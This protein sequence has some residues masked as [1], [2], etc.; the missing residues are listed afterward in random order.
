MKPRTLHAVAYDESADLLYV[1][2]GTDLNEVLDN[3]LYYNFTMNK[4]ISLDDESHDISTDYLS[5]KNSTISEDDNK[6]KESLVE[7]LDFKTTE[8][9][10][11]PD[12]S[13]KKTIKFTKYNKTTVSVQMFAPPPVK[14]GE[15][16][17]RKKRMI[18]ETVLINEKYS[19]YHDTFSSKPKLK[20]HKMIIVSDGLLIYGGKSSN[21]LS[22]TLWH[23]NIKSLL[24]SKK[25]VKSKVRPPPVW[26]HCVVKMKTYMYSFGGSTIGGKFISD[27]YRINLKDLKE[28]EKVNV[29]AGKEL[30]MRLTGHSCVEHGGSILVFGGLTT[31]MARFSKLTRKLFTFDS[32][33]SVWSEI[34][35]PD[36]IVPPEMAYHTSVIVGNYMVVFGGYVHMHVKYEKCYESSL[37]FFNLK[38]HTWQSVGFEHNPPR[39]G[40]PKLQGVFGHGAVVRKNIQI[41]ISGGYHGSVTGDLLGYT[42]PGTLA[43]MET[44]CHFYGTQSSCAANPLCGWCGTV[45]QCY[46]AHVTY[47][48]L[49]K[50]ITKPCPGLCSA[51]GNC[52]DCTVTGAGSCSWCV[53]LGKCISTKDVEAK[54]PQQDYPWQSMPGNIND[55]SNC[56]KYDMKPGVTVSKYSYVKERPADFYPEKTYIANSSDVFLS[57]S[58]IG[59]RRQTT[60]FKLKGKIHPEYNPSKKVMHLQACVAAGEGSLSLSTSP[61]ATPVKNVLNISHSSSSHFKRTC[62]TPRWPNTGEFI[63]LFP[64][65]LTYNFEFESKISL[66]DIKGFKKSRLTLQDGDTGQVFTT[67]HLEP[68]KNGSCESYKYCKQ[69]VEDSLC[70]WCPETKACQQR[71]SSDTN[72]TSFL[73]I[74]SELCEDCNDYVYCEQCLSNPACQWHTEEVTCARKGTLG[75]NGVIEIVEACPT[76]C[77][78]RSSCSDCLEHPGRCVWCQ[79]RSECLL[80]SVYTSEFQFGECKHWTDLSDLTKN[81]TEKCDPCSVQKTCNECQQVLG[82]GWC[83]GSCTSKQDCQLENEWEY[84]SCPDIDECQLDLHNCHEHAVCTNTARSFM[85]HCKQGYLGDGKQSCTKTCY[86]G[87]GEH[88]KCSGYPNYQCQ[89]NLGWTGTTCDTWCECN[90]FSTCHT[91]VG[92]CDFC[93]NNTAGFNCENCSEG[94]ILSYSQCTSCKDYCHGHSDSCVLSSD[95]TAHICINCQN[96]TTGPRCDQCLPGTF[97]TSGSLSEGCDKC[98]CNGHGDTCHPHT[99]M[100]CNCHN[101][102]ITET[103]ITNCKSQQCWQHQCAKC[104]Q[105]FIGDPRQG[106]HCYRAMMVNTDY[107][108]DDDETISQPDFCALHTP[109]LPGKVAFFAVQ[110]KFM[111]VHIRVNVDMMDGEV[112][113]FLTSNSQLFV[114]Q[115]NSTNLHNIRLDQQ[116]FKL[117]LNIRDYIEHPDNLETILINYPHIVGQFP[118]Y[119][120]YHNRSKKEFYNLRIKQASGLTTFLTLDNPKEVLLVQNVR[121]RLVLSIPETSHDLR[122]SKFYL[123][124]YGKDQGNQNTTDKIIGN[125]FFRQDQLHIDLFVFFS[126][127]FS[128]FFLFLSFCIVVWKLKLTV[129]IR[130]ARRRHAVEMTIMAQRPF[131]KQLVVIDNS[132]NPCLHQVPQ[133]SSPMPGRKKLKKPWQSSR[134]VC[135]IDYH[136]GSSVHDML[137]PVS[138]L[139]PAVTAISVEPTADNLAAVTSLLVQMPGPGKQKFLQIGSVLTN[140]IKT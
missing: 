19:S 27:I 112:D 91:G 117:T 109:V 79:S 108:L 9:P 44:P 10:E 104:D 121:N 23:F 34:N 133:S 76:E 103:T 95:S 25:A 33:H 89:C 132:E 15:K 63:Y 42:V 12:N 59:L 11:I 113:V 82:C 45:G 119:L 75:S 35:Y 61:P 2:G 50:L 105:Y 110:P 17:N 20:G 55:P 48:C 16:L 80:F 99:G 88:G 85:C 68:Y 3:F 29:K 101:N 53:H 127:F 43:R 39:H 72:C 41:I 125:I 62:E 66:M 120:V 24:W 37:F 38:C 124:L 94:F 69:C 93:Q 77:S 28:W 60:M 118:S 128:C 138:V 70:G 8:V 14:D 1:H 46:P 137:L 31:D 83:D 67:G 96:G 87:C 135:D 74:S 129:D 58:D 40:Y 98:Y 32:E 21:G 73:V 140:N 106:H 49:T 4:W 5:S 22:N 6:V 131:S 56:T 100:G 126:C 102:T 139:D 54:C 123:L 51:L 81:V 47:M 78:E 71:E 111:N 92:V 13:H 57:T 65:L 114:V 7:I 30:D 36:T 122:S 84:F 64:T 115:Q 134:Q 107:C 90:G 116:Q 97:R 18:P 136:P 26:L 130:S 86:P 52:V